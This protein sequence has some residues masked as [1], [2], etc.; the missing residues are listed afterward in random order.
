MLR[1]TCQAVGALAWMVL[2]ADA[3]YAQGSIVGIVRDTS[4]AVLPGVTVEAASPAL[5]EKV[6]SVVTDG[7]GQYQIVSLVPGTYTVTYTLPGFNTVRRDGIEIAG[8][9]TAKVD[10]EMRVGAVEETITVTGEA[11]VV[12]VQSPRQQRV[13]GREV[14]DLI[15]VG[16]SAIDYAAL[17]PGVSSSNRD[18]GGSAVLVHVIRTA[19]VHGGGYQVILRNG[20][21]AAGQAGNEQNTPVNLNPSSAREVVVDTAAVGPEYA[22]NGVRINVIPREGG[23]T[24][25]GLMFANFATSAMQSDNFSDELKAAGLVQ[26]NTLKHAHDLNPGFGGPLKQD[27]LWFFVAARQYVFEAYAPVFYNLNANNPNAWTYEPDV[28]RPAY[29]R[30]RQRDGQLRLTWQATANNKIGITWQEAPA[31]FDPNEINAETSPDGSSIRDWAVQRQGQVDWSSPVTNRVL[32]EAGGNFYREFSNIKDPPGLHPAMIRVVEQSTGL[33][34]RA[35]EVNRYSPR[36]T[37]HLM[38]AASY[39]TGTHQFKVGFHHTHGHNIMGNSMPNGQPVSYRFNNGVPNRITQTAFPIESKTETRH[40]FGLYLQDKWTIQRLTATYGG[41]FDY[42]AGGWAEDHV[43][44]APLAPTRNLTFPAASS[45]SWKDITP[46]V[47][48]VYDLFGTGR[49]ALKFSLKKGLEGVD[50]RTDVVQG[51]APIN[52][53]VNSTTRSWNDAN[54]NFVPDCN[55]LNPAS[56]GECGGLANQNFGSSTPGATFDPDLVRGWDKRGYNW[57]FS[58]IVQQEI[59]ARTS[60]DVGYFRRSFGNQRFT[61]NRANPLS[62]FDFFDIT[63]PVDPRLPGGGGYVIH[64]LYDLKPEFFGRPADGLVTL[65]ENIGK[66]THVWEGVDLNINIRPRGGVLLQGGFSTGHTTRDTCDLI[67]KAPAPLNTNTQGLVSAGQIT[68][69]EFCHR[70]TPWL[71]Q[72]K[73]IG[74]YTVPIVDIGISATF[75]DV[76]GEEILANYN[77]PTAVAAQALGR[78]L[79]GGAANISVPIVRAGTIYGERSNQVDLRISKRLTLGRTRASLNL[80]LFNAFN[81]NSVIE[82]NNNFAVWQTPTSIMLARFAKVGMQV[83]F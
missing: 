82:Y 79:S 22:Q 63:A 64:G 67:A 24:F 27:R 68:P 70:D 42:Y 65:S 26:P 48:A 32:F 5:I 69:L 44:P 43:G 59:L 78:P 72:V 73:F 77:L 76:P 61:D 83:D 46:H 66:Q 41:R 74:S 45:V 53:L 17:I 38:G 49:T 15:P 47:G 51:S 28:S 56:N 6:R 16:R 4:G 12:D 75:Q 8:S 81:D 21:M 2:V 7:T 10:A 23:N 50:A 57:E 35:P 60:L 52:R 37:V 34:Y 1:R 3:A 9:F 19:S 18:V 71:T 58:A 11:P 55:L 33:G 62:A 31:T 39:I 25:S 29:N 14:I 20:V 36:F 30:S 80:D 13:V 40:N 54:R